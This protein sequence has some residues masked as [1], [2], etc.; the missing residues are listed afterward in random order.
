MSDHRGVQGAV[1][2]GAH[3][4][5]TRVQIP[6]PQ[7]SSKQSRRMSLIE[8][9]ANVAV[10]FLVALLTQIVVFPLFNLEV[11]L[12]EHLAISGL[13]TIASIAR[14]YLLRRLFEAIRVAQAEP[15]EQPV[16]ALRRRRAF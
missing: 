14:S 12:G 3:T 13:F 15:A 11:G 1:P 4:P 9:I 5:E 7:P 8:A 2:G 16:A 6:P 10:G